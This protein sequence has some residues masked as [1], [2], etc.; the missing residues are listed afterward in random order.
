MNNI[1]LYSKVAKYLVVDSEQHQLDTLLEW[2]KIVYNCLEGGQIE[3]AK[4]FLEQAI[5]E[6]EKPTKD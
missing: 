2:C 6:A 3:D 5:I 1:R 4:V